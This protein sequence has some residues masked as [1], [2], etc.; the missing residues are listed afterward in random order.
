MHINLQNKNKK[1]ETKKA[2]DLFNSIK[3]T[4]TKI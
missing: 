1:V 2:F 4:C 3:L